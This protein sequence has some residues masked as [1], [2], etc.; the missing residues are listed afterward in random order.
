MPLLAGSRQSNRDRVFVERERHAQ[1]RRGDLSYPARAVRTERSPYVSNVRPDRWPAGDPEMHVAVGRSATRCG[2]QELLLD[3]AAIG[4]RR[5]FALAT[6]SVPPEELYDRRKESGSNVTWLDD[7]STV[8][9]ALRPTSRSG[10][11]T[12]DREPRRTMT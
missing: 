7:P 2:L 11:A 3:A 12:Q 5:A 8:A 10:C 4:E 6:A 9:L 1:V